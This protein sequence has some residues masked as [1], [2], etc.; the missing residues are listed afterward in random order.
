M[1]EEVVQA[2]QVHADP[3][4]SGR[5]RPNGDGSCASPSAGHFR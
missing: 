4:G 3:P 1:E 5:D 2:L